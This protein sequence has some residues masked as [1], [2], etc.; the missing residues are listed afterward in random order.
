MRLLG[1]MRPTNRKF[2]KPSSRKRERAGRAGAFLIVG[3]D[4]ISAV[5][6]AIKEGS[7]LA[8]ADQHADR[9][10]VFGIEFALQLVKGEA[11]SADKTTPVDLVTAES[12]EKP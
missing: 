9:L 10:A 6:A 12:L 7:I 1:A 2:T 4:G 11:P 5:A 3:Y 8:T